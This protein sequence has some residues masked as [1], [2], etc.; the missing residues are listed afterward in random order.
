MPSASSTLAIVS[1]RGFASLASDLY[2]LSRDT[3]AS[4]A[5]C[6]MPFALAAVSMAFNKMRLSFASAA[7]VAATSRYGFNWFHGRLSFMVW[8][9]LMSAF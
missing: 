4:L 1:K 2:K 5:T 7:S 9:C 6:I 8:A 3:P